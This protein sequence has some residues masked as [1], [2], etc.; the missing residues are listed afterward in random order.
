VEITRDIANAFNSR[1]GETFVEPR[2]IIRE[3]GAR[4]MSLEDPTKKMSKSDGEGSYIALLDPPAMIR[5]KIARATTDSLRTIEF[6]ENR[7]GISN[8][9]TIYQSMSGASREQIEAEF[10]GKGY[11]EFK[12][13]LGDALVATLEPIQRRYAELMADPATLEALMAEGAAKIRP[14][15]ETTLQTVMERV[16]LR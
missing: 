11:K 7:P 4:I 3:V 1:F 9:L 15:A 5:K 6:D 12:A 10:A 2:P 13:A 16:G 8:L 14:I